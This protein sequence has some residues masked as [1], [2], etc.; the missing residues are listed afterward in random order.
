LDRVRRLIAEHH[1]HERLD[2]LLAPFA[3]SLDVSSFVTRGSSGDVIGVHAAQHCADLIVLGGARKRVG[4]SPG[5][6][7]SMLSA[8]AERGVLTVPGESPSCALRTILL[9]VTA[10]TP[11]SPALSW[12]TMLARGFGAR[13]KLVG[14]LPTSSGFWRSAS[15]TPVTAA[16]END[17]RLAM[18]AVARSLSAADVAT[19]AA[20]RSMPSA[21]L[22]SVVDSRAFDLVVLGLPAG[23]T[24]PE[25][26]LLERLRKNGTTPVLSI[27]ARS[28]RSQAGA[29]RFMENQELCA[30]A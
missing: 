8:G 3:S 21:E 4:A 28:A 22:E 19:S 25:A 17:L 1:A 26:A 14:V 30:S 16:R 6:L 27:R 7:A 9:P 11:D 5:S 2:A 10:A 18:R 24:S 12:I 15:R 20:S 23:V 13:V 29:L